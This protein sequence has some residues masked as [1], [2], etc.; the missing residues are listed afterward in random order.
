[1]RFVLLR[2]GGE[3]WSKLDADRTEN[4]SVRTQINPGAKLQVRVPLRL[5]SKY[6]RLCGELDLGCRILD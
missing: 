1:M 6:G 4:V 2:Q 5:P 3:L